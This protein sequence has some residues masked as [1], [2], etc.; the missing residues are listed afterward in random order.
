MPGGRQEAPPLAGSTP[1]IWGLIKEANLKGPAL[2][3]IYISWI[4]QKEKTHSKGKRA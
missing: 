1:V 3:H 2:G 4:H